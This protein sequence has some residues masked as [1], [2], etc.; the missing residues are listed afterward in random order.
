MDD[1]EQ[2]AA[3]GGELQLADVIPKRPK[4][5]WKYPYLLKL[6]VLLMAGVLAQVVSGYDGSMLNGLQALESWQEYFDDPAG[7][8]LGTMT[9]GINIGILIT[10]PFVW[11]MLEYIG[12]KPSLIIGCLVIIL[13]AVIQ[14]VARNFSMFIAA[15]IL[16]GIGGGI[17]QT[18]GPVYLAECAYPSHRPTMTSLLLASWP[19]GSFIASLV[20]WGPYNSSMKYNNWSWRI[21]SLIQAVLPAVQVVLAVLGPESP[22]WLISKGKTEAA[23]AFFSKYHGD[24]DP[25]SPLVQFQMAEI[26]ATIEAE[27]VQKQTRWTEFFA[28][29]A[30]LHRLFI[31]LA[32]PAMQQLCGNSV[33]AY[34]L[35]LILDNLGITN[36]LDQLKINIGI[37]VFSLVCSVI[38]ASIVY[39]HPRRHMLMAGY[40]VMCITFTIFT[41]VSA[42]N[43]ERNFADHSLA[44]GAVVMIY[45]FSGAY[46][47]ASPVPLT[48]IMEINPFSLRA[49]ASMLYQ[50]SGTA[51][52]LF[53]GYVN[54]IAMAAIAWKYYI[55]WD[56]WLVVQTLVVYFFFPETHGLGLEEVA[57]VF[58]DALVDSDTAIH[59][60]AVVLDDAASDKERPTEHV[61]QVR[62]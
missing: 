24:G 54:P 46:H 38:F 3:P 22:R 11:A 61:E 2:A 21:P 13:G 27:K 33:L 57:Q 4:M 32:L 56:V 50:L 15:R 53:N 49:K 47:I 36:S 10:M 14:G 48:Y 26:S 43:Q 1:Q 6:N 60:M 44:I 40:I 28:T 34:Y 29:R 18:A 25:A 37:T 7:S 51:I 58:G 8:R 23:L 19:F 20:T 62:N 12:R 5:W 9:N 42:I 16:L 59:K 31:T 45:A 30:M 41:I 17:A 52:M 35:H 39:K 55:V